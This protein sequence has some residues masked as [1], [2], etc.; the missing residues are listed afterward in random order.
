MILLNKTN[1]SRN[2]I[3]PWPLSEDGMKRAPRTCVPAR[4]PRLTGIAELLDYAIKT[5]QI[6]VPLFL[7]VGCASTQT[8]NRTEFENSIVT[9]QEWGGVAADSGRVHQIRSITLHHEGESF[10]PGK[11]PI[12]YL[13]NLQ[14]WSRTEKHWIDIPYHY[15][16][17]LNGRVYE[18][19]PIRFAGDTNTDYDPA[20]HALVCVVG[21]FEE[22]EP[23]EA[24]LRAVVN[25][26]TWLC[27]KYDITP[28]KIRGHKDLASGTVCPGKN[29]Y[30][31]LQNG[32]LQK[33]VAKLMQ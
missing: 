31:Y 4:G 7:L 3:I 10:P 17:D 18:G 22:V 9:Q 24:Q 20:G 30:R 11:D 12:E 16:I 14:K 25:V 2:I 27:R 28:D 1:S 21:N 33:E 29:L 13:R 23:N 26:F 32:Y 5:A 15:I 8:F 6:L 19:R